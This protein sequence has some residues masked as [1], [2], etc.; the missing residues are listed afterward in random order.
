LLV[1][2]DG[3]KGLDREARLIYSNINNPGAV[4][5]VGV[6]PISRILGNMFIKLRQ[7]TKAKLK[8]FALEDAALV[9]SPSNNHRSL[10]VG[11]KSIGLGNTAINI[12]RN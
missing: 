8:M 3:I 7:P 4:A 5:L 9:A 11:E 1:L 2:L 10:R 12:I 6:S